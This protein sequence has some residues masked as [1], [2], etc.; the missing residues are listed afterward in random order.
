MLSLRSV[1]FLK[2]ILAPLKTAKAT[3]D[4]ID[5]LIFYL[6]KTQCIILIILLSITSCNST[7]FST[8]R[9]SELYEVSQLNGIYENVPS[10]MYSS[11]TLMQYSYKKKL[12]DIFNIKTDSVDYINMKFD[13]KSLIITLLA[14]SGIQT[15]SFKGKLKNNFFQIYLRRYFVPIPFIYFVKQIE[16]VRIGQNKDNDLFIQY[17]EDNFGWVP[18]MA[19]GTTYDYEYIFRK[20][21]E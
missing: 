20:M 12:S 16:R 7:K 5:Y 3:I 6:M 2:K 17:W 13:K 4:I 14:D 18:I 8:N 9:F 21:Q 1:F 15:I 11:D 10:E 19:S